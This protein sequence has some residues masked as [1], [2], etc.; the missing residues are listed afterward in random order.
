MIDKEILKYYEKELESLINVCNN[1]PITMEELCSYAKL[2]GLIAEKG[3]MPIY[4]QILLDGSK[5]YDLNLIK[6]KIKI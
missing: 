1:Y 3:K 6:R 2:L 5:Y 4:K